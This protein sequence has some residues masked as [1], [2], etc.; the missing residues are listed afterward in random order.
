M[1]QAQKEITDFDVKIY[2]ASIVTFK[3]YQDYFGDVPYSMLAEQ[4]LSNHKVQEFLQKEREMIS[5]KK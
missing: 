4:W 1:N 5:F 3:D 2:K